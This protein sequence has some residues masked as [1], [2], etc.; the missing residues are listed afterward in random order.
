[1]DIIFLFFV[2]LQSML[3]ESNIFLHEIYFI[4]TTW[5][6]ISSEQ[7]IFSII[8]VKNTCLHV[9][10]IVFCYECPSENCPMPMTLVVPV[11]LILLWSCCMKTIA[12]T[13]LVCTC[14]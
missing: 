10:N 8:P 14:S 12:Q 11:L 3:L 4:F 13:K 5:H 1:M 9:I 2:T 7:Y 6:V